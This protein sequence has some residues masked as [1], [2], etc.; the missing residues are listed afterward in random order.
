MSFRLTNYTMSAKLVDYLLWIC[1][2]KCASIEVLQLTVSVASRYLNKNCAYN[3][4]LQLVFLTSLYIAGKVVG[5]VDGSSGGFTI[6][7]LHKYS[8]HCFTN[9]GRQ[10]TI[11]IFIA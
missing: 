9:K 2:E 8:S 10:S 5:N 11:K 1:H 4:P 6:N 3:E 7:E